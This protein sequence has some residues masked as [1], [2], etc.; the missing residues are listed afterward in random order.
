M[1]FD[2]TVVAIKSFYIPSWN[3]IATL[4]SINL[5]LGQEEL[6]NKHR[7]IKKSKPYKQYTTIHNIDYSNDTAIQVNKCAVYIAIKQTNNRNI[8]S[9]ILLHYALK[10]I[11]IAAH[12]T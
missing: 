9:S 1:V 10:T 5:E 2:V 7:T 4:R 8:K 11:N 6:N 3:E 12:A